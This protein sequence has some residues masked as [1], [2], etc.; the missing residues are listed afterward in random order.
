MTLW[1]QILDKFSED[2][3]PL[4]QALVWHIEFGD[5]DAGNAWAAEWL[6]SPESD[7]PNKLSSLIKAAPIRLEGTTATFHIGE[8]RNAASP[9]L[10]GASVVSATVTSPLDLIAQK[11][12][13]QVFFWADV[14]L[15]APE[16]FHHK[17]LG[18]PWSLKPGRLPAPKTQEPGPSSLGY[19]DEA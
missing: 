19:A 11:T 18:F 2:A 5:G 4:V 16:I 6:A 8:P 1:Q 9:H 3:R 13:W 17:N 10:L 14:A 7:G 15:V 12:I